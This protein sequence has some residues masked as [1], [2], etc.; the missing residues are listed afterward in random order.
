MMIVCKN[1]SCTWTYHGLARDKKGYPAVQCAAWG[2]ECPGWIERRMKD[3]DPK[4]IPQW[5]H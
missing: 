2:C 3:E 5:N 4:D 1:C